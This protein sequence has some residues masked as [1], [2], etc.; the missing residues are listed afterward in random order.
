MKTHRNAILKGVVSRLRQLREQYEESAIIEH[1]ATKGSLREAYLK[2]FLADFVPYPFVLTS[3]FITDCRGDRITPQI[4]L[5]VFDRTSVPAFALNQFVSILP[6]ETVRLL[7]EVKSLLQAKHF[8]QIQ[9]QQAAI[10]E[11]RFAWTTEGRKYL[12]MVDCAGMSH[13]VFAFETECSSDTLM[14]WFTQEAHLE[15]ICVVGKFILLRD[16][17][18]AKVEL[19]KADVQFGEV[20]HFLRLLHATI[21]SNDRELRISSHATPEGELTLYPDLGAYLT[22]DV[23]Y[24]VVKSGDDISNNP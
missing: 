24:P 20:L 14:E 1:N 3:G 19:I 16:P 2:Q 12:K 9:E 13:F 10:R 22:F 23:P 18:T 17:N 4:D 7:I 15:A 21:Q 5:L 6:L 11:L 8:Q